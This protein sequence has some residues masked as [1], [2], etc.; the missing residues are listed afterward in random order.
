MPSMVSRA[1][2]TGSNL[3]NGLGTAAGETLG[4][5]GGAV[6]GQFRHPAMDFSNL[7]PETRARNAAVNQ[8]QRSKLVNDRAAAG[9]QAGPGALKALL[10]MAAAYKAHQMMQ[11]SQEDQQYQQF[12]DTYQY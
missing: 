12:G 11:P 10:A 2:T 1:M 5:I 9:R 7:P 8:I 3:V 4:T 6:E